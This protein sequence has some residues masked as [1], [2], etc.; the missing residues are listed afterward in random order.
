MV[1][2]FGLDDRQTRQVFFDLQELAAYHRTKVQ[3]SAFSYSPFGMQGVQ[4]IAYEIAEALPNVEHVFT[5]AG[6]GGLT[7]A[8]VRGFEIWSKSNVSFKVPHVHCVQPRGNDTIA[9]AL[10]TGELKAR[11][12]S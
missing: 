1:K 9:S 6:G 8:M 3:I 10:Q 5:P 11:S 4:T 7:L 12:H 2:D